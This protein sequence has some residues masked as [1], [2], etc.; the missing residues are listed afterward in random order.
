MRLLRQIPS[1]EKSV[2]PGSLSLSNMAMA[3]SVFRQNNIKTSEAKLAL[4]DQLQNKSSREAEKIVASQFPQTVKEFVRPI[5][6]DQNQM[7]MVISD[8]LK[9]K[10]EKLKALHA[11]K[12]SDTTKLLEY[13]CD[14]ELAEL[15]PTAPAGAEL[16]LPSTSQVKMRQSRT[17]YVPKPVKR[18]VWQRDQGKCKNCG[19]QAYLQLD[20]ILPFSMGGPSSTENLRLLCRNCNQRSA[21]DKIG[22]RVASAST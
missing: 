4:L 1:L 3:Q 5:A 15:T 13:L 11:H 18:F 2:Q 12:F 21:V 6:E 14:K 19:T 7:Q 9:A 8:A 20:H 10:I 22:T 17:R 16:K